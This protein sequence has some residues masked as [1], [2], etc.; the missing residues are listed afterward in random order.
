[1]GNNQQKQKVNFEDV[2]FV[3]KNSDIGKQF[4][5]DCVDSFNTRCLKEDGTLGGKWAGTCYEQGIMNLM[6]SNKYTK[7]TTVL[8]NSIIFNYNVCSDEVFIMHLYAS[9]PNYRVQCFHSKNPAL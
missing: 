6:I 2:Q 5:N 1:M 8:T 7:N 3:I 4:L 9:E